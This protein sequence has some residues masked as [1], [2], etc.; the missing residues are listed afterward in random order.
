MWNEWEIRNKRGSYIKF[1]LADINEFL[2]Y[3]YKNKLV[4][5][6]NGQIIFSHIIIYLIM[7]IFFFSV[8]Y[9]FEKIRNAIGW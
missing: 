2:S 1:L 8:F 5:Q 4:D 6:N 7:Q 9:A 3:L